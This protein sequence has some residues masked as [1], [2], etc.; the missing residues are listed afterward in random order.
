[1]EGEV[2]QKSFLQL[3][4]TAERSAKLTSP[5]QVVECLYDGDNRTLKMAQ[6][7]ERDEG[8]RNRIP[9]GLGWRR[10][11]CALGALVF[12]QFATASGVGL[13]VR[14]CRC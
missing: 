4:S 9:G 10:P 14:S 1:V 7:R 8:H 13:A 5:T 3:L 6:P 12:L 2:D 11:L